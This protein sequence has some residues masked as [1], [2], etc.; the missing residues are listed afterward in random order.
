MLA[1]RS[2]RRVKDGGNH[3]VEPGSFREIAILGSVEGAF[4]IINFRA[5]MDAAG[6]RF[7]RSLVRIEGSKRGK[8]A[9]GEIDFGDV[10]I[11]AEIFHAIGEGGIELRSV[12]EIEKRALGI[13][14]GDDGYDGDFFAVREND[15]GD[16]AVLDSNVLD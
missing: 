3:H 8:P 10:A 5:D 16:G 14:A 15:A 4:K 9:E 6:E 12:H 11:G 2:E 7:E 1:V 13:G